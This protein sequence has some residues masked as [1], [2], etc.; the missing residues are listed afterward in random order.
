MNTSTPSE[1]PSLQWEELQFNALF[2][3]ATLGIVVANHQGDILLANP[4][5]EKQFGYS[6]QEL[7]GRKVEAL[8]PENFHHIHQMHRNHY[9]DHPV[10]RPMGLGLDLFARRKD[11]SVFPVEISL[12]PY[13]TPQGMQVIA[14]I[15]DVSLRKQIEETLRLKQREL[16]QYAGEL[17]ASNKELENFAYISSHDLQEPLRKIQ[18]FADR[19][20]SLEGDKLSDQGR[21]Y[22]SR[23]Q[24]AAARMQRLI[25]DLLNFSRITSSGKAFVRTD[26]NE[27]LTEV[28]DDLQVSIEASKARI[29]F[30]AMPVIQAVPSQMRQLF[31]NLI[32]NALKFRKP[33]QQPELTIQA[34]VSPG[35]TAQEGQL[36]LHFKDK[37]KGFSDR[38]SEKIFDIFQRLDP[39]GPEGSGIGLA[40]CK[41]IVQQHGGSIQAHGEPGV[42]AEFTV[43]LPYR[44][45]PSEAPN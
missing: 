31:Q 5:A 6:S 25:N 33:E 40:V 37:G 1:D 44:A 18:T 16:E 2:N 3:N 20:R 45:S 29:R 17:E 22:F 28:L 42:G 24:Q 19:I 13:H 30:D 14:F 15:V 21:D 41:K 32:G 43:T 4:F 11:G 35:S 9:V 12:S 34:E 7:I 38:Y 36:V 27:V 8:I 10:S 39:S 26:L 23:I